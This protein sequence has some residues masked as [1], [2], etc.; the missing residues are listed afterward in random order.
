MN[1]WYIALI[2][3]A[4]VFCLMAPPVPRGGTRVMDLRRWKRFGGTLE[5]PRPPAPIIRGGHQLR[6]KRAAPDNP[7]SGGSSGRRA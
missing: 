4:V 5:R 1:G 6:T 2:A 7:P 3:V